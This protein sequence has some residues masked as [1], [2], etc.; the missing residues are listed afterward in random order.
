VCCGAVALAA[1][2]IVAV[3]HRQPIG[4]ALE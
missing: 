3:R 1:I 2:G 4:S